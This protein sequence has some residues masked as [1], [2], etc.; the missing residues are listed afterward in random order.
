MYISPAP[1]DQVVTL[2]YMAELAVVGQHNA[3]TRI[4]GM[5]NV[6]TPQSKYIIVQWNITT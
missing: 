1:P 3:L 5:V 2:S 6:H 4:R